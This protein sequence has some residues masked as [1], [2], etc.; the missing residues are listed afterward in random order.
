[1]IQIDRLPAFDDNYL[2]GLREG[3]AAWVVDP[4]DADVVL[5][6]LDRSQLTLE[7]ILITHHHKDHSGGI[8]RL[9]ERYPMAE[10]I[11]S[12]KPVEGVSA[13][14]SEGDVI[15]ILSR[16][17][18]VIE[19][20]GHTLDHVA[21]VSMDPHPILFCGDTLFLGGC[22]RMFEGTPEQFQKSL[23]RLQALPPKTMVFCAHEYTQ[24][25]LEFA[26][27]LLPDNQSVIDRLAIITAMR[28]RGT[29][30][31]PDTLESELHTNPYF[32]LNDPALMAVIGADD[33]TSMPERFARVRK[34]KDNA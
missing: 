26:R 6:W 24:A 12:A 23:E 28:S 14:V 30:T 3:Q 2:W 31:V 9:L 17:F 11:G 20:P 16:R 10:V 8:T 19:V 34:A 1:M 4:G 32:R 29:P 15:D 13:P 5:S 27:Q 33:N 25:N 21:F 7:G 22:G 18:R